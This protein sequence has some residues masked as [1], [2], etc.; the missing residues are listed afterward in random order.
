MDQECSI[1]FD[2]INDSVYYTID[3]KEWLKHKYCMNC[4]KDLCDGAWNLFI[5]NIKKADCEKSLKRCLE[6]GIPD[7]LTVDASLT[8]PMM[9]ELKSGDNI[10]STKLNITISGEQLRNLN[11][12]LRKIYDSMN[13]SEVFDYIGEIHNLLQRYGL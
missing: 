11:I 1:C 6:S 9:L 13:E 12:E 4:L 3:R 2:T 5:S 7:K 8:S 10:I